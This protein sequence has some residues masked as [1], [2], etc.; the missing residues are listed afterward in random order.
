MG[1]RLEADK[2]L[3]PGY[4]KTLGECDLR[5]QLRA[6]LEAFKKDGGIPKWI[7]AEQLEILEHYSTISAACAKI[8]IHGGER[9][10]TCPFRSRRDP[11]IAK[12]QT[13]PKDN[14]IGMTLVLLA[15]EF[16]NH[17]LHKSENNDDL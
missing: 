11:F 8:I 16:C 13:S 2:N 12:A 10:P 9:F 3:C 6:K 17:P 4:V 5:E 1:K 7:S 15:R 14:P